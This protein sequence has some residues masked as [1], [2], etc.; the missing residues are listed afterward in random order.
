MSRGDV[1]TKPNRGQ[2]ENVVEGEPERSASYSSR[3]EAIDQ[4]RALADERG[5]KHVVVDAEPTGDITDP[6]E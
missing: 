3:D 5:A 4:G 6:Q 2:W 1:T